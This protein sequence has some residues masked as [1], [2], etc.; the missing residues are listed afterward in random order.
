MRH[1]E[2]FVVADPRLSEEEMVGLVDDVKSLLGE[3]G[4]EVVKEESWGKRRLAY[5][6][7]KLNEGRYHLLYIDTDG[8]ANPF[9]VVEQRLRQN[10]KVLRYLTIRRETPAPVTEP[11]TVALEVE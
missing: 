5:P 3:G 10:D 11:S 6:I 1:Y 9:R 2:L 8:E 4:G 7:E